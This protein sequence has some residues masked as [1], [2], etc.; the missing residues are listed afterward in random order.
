MERLYEIKEIV[1]PVCCNIYYGE[2]RN[3]IV[4]YALQYA[5]GMDK[6]PASL[7]ELWRK[8]GMR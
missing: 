7:V 5:L 2:L 3:S 4:K 1:C 8:N 6:M